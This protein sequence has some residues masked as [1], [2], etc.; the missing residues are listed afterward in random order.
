MRSSGSRVDWKIFFVIFTKLIPRKMFFCIAKILV[1]MVLL[2]RKL[3]CLDFPWFI[4]RLAGEM[5]IGSS[6]GMLGHCWFPFETHRVFWGA[7]K[8]TWRVEKDKRW[9]Y[10]A[11][12]PKYLQNNQQYR[13]IR[14]YYLPAKQMSCVIEKITPTKNNLVNQWG[15]LAFLD[16]PSDRSIFSTSVEGYTVIFEFLH[17]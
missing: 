17:F 11:Q 7:E 12:E 10:G 3:S 9:I 14:N 16:F 1:L 4:N 5:W 8:A 2:G 13:H 6:F 15:F